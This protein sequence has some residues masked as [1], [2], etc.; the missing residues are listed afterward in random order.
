M[1]FIKI[2]QFIINTIFKMLCALVKWY[3]ICHDNLYE[4]FAD[5]SVVNHEV[6]IYKILML[7]LT[8]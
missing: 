7:I 4:K 6:R 1:C 2:Y 8:D 5:Y 3:T